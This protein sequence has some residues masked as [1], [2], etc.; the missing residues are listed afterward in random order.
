MK[1][2]HNSL[3]GYLAESVTLNIKEGTYNHISIAQDPIEI[4]WA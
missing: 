4:F 1:E 3:L 2:I